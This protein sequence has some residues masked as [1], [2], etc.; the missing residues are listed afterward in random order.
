MVGRYIYLFINNLAVDPL[1][2]RFKI[3]YSDRLRES[4][5]REFEINSENKCLLSF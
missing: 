4:W 5:V 1:A 3:T 2:V